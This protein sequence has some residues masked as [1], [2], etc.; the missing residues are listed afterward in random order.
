MLS[1]G[2]FSGEVA[3]VSEIFFE[4][5]RIM[6]WVSLVQLLSGAS[7]QGAAIS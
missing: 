6:K 5:P 7:L 4:L 3:R 1:I 2:I